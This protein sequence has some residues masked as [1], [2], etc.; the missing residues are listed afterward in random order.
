[1]RLARLSH[2]DSPAFLKDLGV[3]DPRTLPK[4]GY[5]AL[6]PDDRLDRFAV[7]IRAE[8]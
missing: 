8:R 2:E 1:M 7:A 3:N 6:A 4:I 5:I